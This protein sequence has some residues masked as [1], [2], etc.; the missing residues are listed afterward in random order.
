ML[1]EKEKTTAGTEALSR[2]QLKK[3]LQKDAICLRRAARQAIQ[4]Q[5]PTQAQRWLADNFHLLHAALADGKRAVS[6]SRRLAFAKPDRNC[7][8]GSI[9]RL[10][11]LC[12]S[13]CAEGKLPSD[14]AFFRFFKS[15]NL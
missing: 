5:E 6:G 15:K 12:L 7:E 4:A 8:N 2:R 13:L 10:F 3:Q 9:G 11:L 1:T 14:D